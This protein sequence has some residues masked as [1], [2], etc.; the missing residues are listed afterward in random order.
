[1]I[2]PDAQV[3][4]HRAPLPRIETNT[5]WPAEPDPTPWRDEMWRFQREVEGARIWRLIEEASR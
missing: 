4:G 2:P 1:M 5:I 3:I